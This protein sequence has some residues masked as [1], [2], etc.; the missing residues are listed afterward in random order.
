MILG[1]IDAALTQ[2]VAAI[3]Q[4]V[5]RLLLAAFA[6]WLL[7]SAFTGQTIAPLKMIA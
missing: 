1:Q 7:Y 5:R 6:L 2:I 4:P 3:P